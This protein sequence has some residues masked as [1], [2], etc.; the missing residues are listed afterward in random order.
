MNFVILSSWTFCCCACELVA[1]QVFITSQ[2]SNPENGR[3]FGFSLV[4]PIDLF[5]AIVKPSQCVARL[6][7]LCNFQ[8]ICNRVVLQSESY[9]PCAVTFVLICPSFFLSS[10]F[11]IFLPRKM[12]SRIPF[13]TLAN[14]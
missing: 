1:C 4:A 3:G 10:E 6:R 14:R 9:A 11:S 5:A 8:A 13:I 7:K 2:L 12:L